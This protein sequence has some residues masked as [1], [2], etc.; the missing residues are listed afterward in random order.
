MFL[1]ATVQVANLRVNL[2]LSVSLFIPRTRACVHVC[3]IKNTHILFSLSLSPSLSFPF[4]GFL[5]Y[6]I[7]PTL[8]KSLALAFSL[9]FFSLSVSPTFRKYLFFLLSLFPFRSLIF[10]L[11]FSL[12]KYLPT[13][14]FPPFP[15]PV[16]QFLSNSLIFFLS[17]YFS[18]FQNQ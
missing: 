18:V 10:I 2:Q 6:V 12:S 17:L 4:S 7:S 9:F 15:L 1:V 11:I 14:F 5:T 8:F 3:V 16:F 13:S